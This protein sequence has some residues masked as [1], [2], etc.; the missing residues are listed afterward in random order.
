[1][2]GR[3]WM[4][5]ALVTG[6]C[7][8]L[9]GP[10]AARADDAS[11]KPGKDNAY[12]VWV[13]VVTSKMTGTEIPKELLQLSS[14]SPASLAP[15]GLT[16]STLDCEDLAQIDR[17]RAKLP[18]FI[19]GLVDNRVLMAMFANGHDLEY[20]LFPYL[21]DAPTLPPDLKVRAS[22]GGGEPAESIDPQRR[23]Q[24]YAYPAAAL[25]EIRQQESRP[26]TC[27]SR[28]AELLVRR[29]LTFVG[30]MVARAPIPGAAEKSLL[31]HLKERC[32]VLERGIE[33]L[34]RQAVVARPSAENGA[35]PQTGDGCALP[36]ASQQLAG[37]VFDPN[38][39]CGTSR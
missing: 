4:H 3:A 29:A 20:F 27:G 6:A 1:M 39:V 34:S 14:L 25:Y 2:I 26:D 28:R 30:D 8:W 9:G 5:L 16:M 33:R 22:C 7:A 21:V 17:V 23:T 35:S 31:D 24:A 15:A 13:N 11:C 10:T 12:M 18:A 38:S 36:R 32:L 37:L 19:H